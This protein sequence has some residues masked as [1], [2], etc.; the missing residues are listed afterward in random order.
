MRNGQRCDLRS[1]PPLSLYIYFLS[2]IFYFDS[3]RYLI[4]L[5]ASVYDYLSATPSTILLLQIPPLRT[6]LSLL[7]SGACLRIIFV[8]RKNGGRTVYKS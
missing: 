8:T 4:P 1:Q 2:L 3:E 6:S 5:A 7:L